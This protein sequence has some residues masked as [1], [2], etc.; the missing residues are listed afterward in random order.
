MLAIDDLCCFYY[1]QAG[2]DALL[3]AYLFVAELS[4]L[5]KQMNKN[6]DTLDF[7]QVEE[8]P[9]SKIPIHSSHHAKLGRSKGCCGLKVATLLAKFYNTVRVT[10]AVPMILKLS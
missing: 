10:N 3:T 8:A 5:L 2:Y 7:A 4:V 6:W 1:L 9:R